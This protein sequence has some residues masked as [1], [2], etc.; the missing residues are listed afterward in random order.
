V[1]TGA[2]GRGTRPVGRSSFTAFSLD[3]LHFVYVI[4]EGDELRLYAIDG[5]GQ[6]FDFARITRTS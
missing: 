5:T 4:I 6:E 1:V 2:G 3:V